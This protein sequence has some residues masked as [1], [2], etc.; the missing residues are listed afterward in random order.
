MHVGTLLSHA[1]RSQKRRKR[2]L[3]SPA[4]WV[5]LLV[6]DRARIVT[7]GVPICKTF[8]SRIL[9]SVEGRTAGGIHFSGNGRYPL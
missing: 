1:C 4:L 2:R 7:V 8:A 3:L 6:G 5:T 9:E